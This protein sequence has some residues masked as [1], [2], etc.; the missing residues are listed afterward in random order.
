MMRRLAILL[1]LLL[2][3]PA[4][5]LAAIQE[6]VGGRL[7]RTPKPNTC[8][9][10]NLTNEANVTLTGTYIGMAGFAINPL[11]QRWYAILQQNAGDT[12]QRV[13]TGR[14]NS[15]TVQD[16]ELDFSGSGGLARIAVNPTTTEIFVSLFNIGGCG[17]NNCLFA[18]RLGPPLTLLASSTVACCNLATG[19]EGITLDGSAFYVSAQSLGT[20]ST[21][22]ERVVQGS[23]SSGTIACT[24]DPIWGTDAHD[25]IDLEYATIL[26]G[27]QDTRAVRWDANTVP[28]T[29]EDDQ[30]LSGLVGGLAGVELDPS[31]TA[32][33][34]WAADVN[35]VGIGVV[36]T[37]AFGSTV[38]FGANEVRR[39]NGL[40][41]DSVNNKLYDVAYDT[42]AQDL[43]VRRLTPSTLAVEQTLTI[44]ETSAINN[45]R[46]LAHLDGPRQ[47]LLIG[48]RGSG[49]V[50]KV[51]EIGLCD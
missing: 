2:G 18:A 14:Y 46:N 21:C 43:I 45:V 38:T 19:N 37:L 41:Y 4:V 27:S 28:P 11:T 30:A 16:R 26:Q 15:L 22:V 49:G 1:V 34:F 40:Q 51:Y 42:V 31:S 20:T 7:A 17:G 39:F 10:F 35:T 47:L 24:T 5:S 50:S 33:R 3:A 48:L 29:F 13:T 36:S 44:A 23:P 25:A 6:Q 8:S 32:D 9:T 12:V